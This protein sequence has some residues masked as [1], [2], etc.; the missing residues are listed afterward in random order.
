MPDKETLLE[1][2]E[3]LKAV[4]EDAKVVAEL[5]GKVT[6][7]LYALA[8]IYSAFWGYILITILSK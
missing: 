8:G 7:M 4:R 1:L 3:V 6:L 5:R 2:I